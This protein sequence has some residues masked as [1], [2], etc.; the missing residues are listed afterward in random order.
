MIEKITINGEDEMSY[1]FNI[2]VQKYLEHRDL[3]GF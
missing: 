2:T 3:N 1:F